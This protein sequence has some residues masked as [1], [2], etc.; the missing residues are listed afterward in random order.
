VQ[1]LPLLKGF[2]M[3]SKLGGYSAHINDKSIP[4]LNGSIIANGKYVTF[5]VPK[6]FN[7]KSIADDIYKADFDF[8]LTPTA[9]FDAPHKYAKCNVVDVQEI[10]GDVESWVYVGCGLEKDSLKQA[11]LKVTI[12][13]AYKSAIK[14]ESK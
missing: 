5:T 3:D 10:T 13:G 6:E 9:A 11:F 2:K 8:I 14:K 7:G 4:V 12:K 1:T